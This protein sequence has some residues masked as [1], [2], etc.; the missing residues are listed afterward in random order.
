MKEVVIHCMGI[1]IYLT[2]INVDLSDQRLNQKLF[3]QLFPD[4]KVF[5]SDRKLLYRIVKACLTALC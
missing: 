4:S 2:S 5:S 1:Y 3:R